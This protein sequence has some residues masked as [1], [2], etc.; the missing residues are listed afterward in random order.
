MDANT[1]NVFISN[2]TAV[3]A[4]KDQYERDRHV[5]DDRLIAAA[6]NITYGEAER[7]PI[8]ALTGGWPYGIKYLRAASQLM[9]SE[10]I[11]DADTLTRSTSV[12]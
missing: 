12:T 3:Q 1:A 4:V 5:V 2:G 10:L 7:R 8:V 9:H 6:Q 11:P